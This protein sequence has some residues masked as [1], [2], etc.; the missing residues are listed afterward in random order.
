M[1]GGRAAGGVRA[2]RVAGVDGARAVGP[3]RARRAGTPRRHDR[4]VGH[5]GRGPHHDRVGGP[6]AAGATTPGRGAKSAAQQC[7]GWYGWERPSAMA[8]ARR[9]LNAS[10]PS[11]VTAGTAEDRP[12]GRATPNPSTTRVP[13]PVQ[14]ALQQHHR[15]MAGIGFGDVATATRKAAVKCRVGRGARSTSIVVEWTTGAWDGSSAKSASER[16]APGRPRWAGRR[17]PTNGVG[18]RARSTRARRPRDPPSSRCRHRCFHLD[19]R[20]VARR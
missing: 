11:S 20:L 6:A 17:Q 8:G 5:A 7:G 2:S 18:D 9:A 1:T 4:R 19:E 16:L 12:R 3:W 15:W 14:D 13:R 10:S